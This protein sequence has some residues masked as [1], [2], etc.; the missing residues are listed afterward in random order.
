MPSQ[1]SAVHKSNGARRR[2]TSSAC[3]S[4][5]ERR[6]RC[7][8]QKPI[9]GSCAQRS[10]VAGW[11]AYRRIGR[12]MD[13]EEYLQVLLCHIREL[14]EACEQAGIPVPTFEPQDSSLES[15]GEEPPS[16]VLKSPFNPPAGF[17]DHGHIPAFPPPIKPETFPSLLTNPQEGD[18]NILGPVSINPIG[19]SEGFLK[20]LNML[21]SPPTA[22]LMRLLAQGPTMSDIPYG[23]ARSQLDGFFLPPRDLADHLLGC[24]WDRVYCLY[25]FF[26]RPSVQ[27]AYES[28]WISCDKQDAKP[29][30]LNIGLGGNSDCGPRSPVFICALNMMFALGCHFA[31]ISVPDRNDIAHAFFL[32][33]RQHIGLD[34]LDIRTVGAVQTLLM[35]ALYL[36]SIPD[37]HKSS[38]MI[39]VACRI[40]QAL[41]LHE[42]QPDDFKDPLELEIQRRTWHGCVMM[43]TVVSMAHGKSSMTSALPTIPLPGAVDLTSTD[44][45]GPYLTA[46]YVSSIELYSILGSILSH[47]SKA[48]CDRSSTSASSAT[49]QQD[50]LDAII[51]LEGRLSEYESDLPSVLRWRQPY[52][53]ATDLLRLS[54]L[55]RQRNVLH[56]RFLYMHLLLYRPAFTQL[57]S[58]VLAEE[59]SEIDPSELTPRTLYSPML[60]KCAADCTKAAIDMISLI[61]DNYQTSTTDTWWYNS[62]YTTTAG[63]VL[64]MAYTCR[65]ALPDIERATIN[66]SWRKCEQILQYMIPY[67]FSARNTLLFLRAAH[68]RIVSYLEEGSETDANDMGPGSNQ[69]SGVENPFAEDSDNHFSGANWL[70]SAVAMVGLGLLCPADF[71]WFQGWLAEELP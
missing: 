54:T 6:T 59:D 9:C 28:L 55:R 18:V 43:D 16:P 15:E 3:E 45:K 60:S 58:E 35:A 42:S 71:K 33:A 65:P 32:R 27:D 38:D 64:V 69:V 23:P 14:E 10:N 13:N 30:K 48:R 67:N 53:P 56:A 8:G 2:K 11:C 12:L 68:G 41:G 44:T 50:T 36:Q 49:V 19:S 34:V 66:E 20:Q 57:C 29:S 26:D 70:G 7:D 1:R 62:F 47:V 51:K 4:C 25:P 40:A 5:R 39:G 22:C 24:F 63:M 31:D 61:Y 17:P 52:N 21:S 46:F 37:P